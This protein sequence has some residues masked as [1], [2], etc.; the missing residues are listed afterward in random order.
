M[1]TVCCDATASSRALHTY[2]PTQITPP[3]QPRVSA[4]GL[5]VLLRLARKGGGWSTRGDWAHSELHAQQCAKLGSEACFTASSPHRHT[6]SAIPEHRTSKA[7]LGLETARTFAGGLH[8]AKVVFLGDDVYV[9]APHHRRQLQ[10]SHAARSQRP[11]PSSSSSRGSHMSM[12]EAKRMQPTCVVAWR[13]RTLPSGASATEV[14]RL[15]HPDAPS[16]QLAAP[17]YIIGPQARSADVQVHHWYPHAAA[18]STTRRSRDLRV[19]PHRWL[20]CAPIAV[21]RI[22][23]SPPRRPARTP[24]PSVCPHD[25]MSGSSTRGGAHTSSGTSCSCSACANTS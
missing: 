6:V 17:A 22:P 9:V 20:A 2:T 19:R 12:Y 16:S 25:P 11:R 8:V 24:V 1:N 4:R 13:E 5:L 18:S 15:A 3:I 7:V 21:V 10:A 14:S 23:R